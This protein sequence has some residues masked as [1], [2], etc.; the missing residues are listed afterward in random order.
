VSDPRIKIGVIG[1]GDVSGLYL[2][3][4]KVFKNVEVAACADIKPDAA[5]ARAAEFGIP[6]VCSVKELLADP[7]IGIVL[8][9]TLPKSHGEIALAALKAGKSVYNEKPLAV[10]RSEGRKMLELAAAKGLRI[11]CAPDVFLGASGQTCRK[12]IDEGLIGEPL[13]ATA[14]LIG[15]TGGPPEA[16]I[17]HRAFKFQAGY[18]PMGNM[19][20]YYLTALVNLIGPIRRVMAM[21]RINL[22]QRFATGQTKAGEV[23]NIEAP[24]TIAGIM[25]F[26]NGAI[27]TITASAD[28]WGGK[29]LP[30]IEIYGTKGSLSLPDPN[31]FGGEVWLRAGKKEWSPVPLSHSYGVQFRGLGV[32]DM[33]KGIQTGRPHR[34]NGEI[35]FH[36]LDA[37]HSFFESGARGRSINLT[38]TCARPAPLPVGLSEGNLD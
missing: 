25:E 7:D 19:A 18:G 6:K 21:T 3:P 4:L 17:P 10:K 15:V 27:G 22:S 36:V 1:C 32:A 33:A 30:E 16:W 29:T 28:I 31:I 23:I 13:A 38:T 8:N 37:I 9:L 20:P 35:A 11:G 34:A 5:K 12:L 2:E 24:T 26:A 14:C